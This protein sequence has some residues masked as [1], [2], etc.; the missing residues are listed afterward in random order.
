MLLAVHHQ[1][2][3]NLESLK[4]T[5]GARVALGDYR[6]EQ[7]IRFFHALQTSRVYHNLTVHTK[8]SSKQLFNQ[9]V[10]FLLDTLVKY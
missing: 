6:L 9:H 10:P 2:M 1:I 5:E 8:A 4:I 3:A 7:P